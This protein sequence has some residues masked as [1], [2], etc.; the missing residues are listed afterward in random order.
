MEF[1][2]LQSRF[3]FWWENVGS[4]VE[5]RSF[6]ALYR[7]EMKAYLLSVA[8]RRGGLTKKDLESGLRFTVARK[9]EA[10]RDHIVALILGGW[11]LGARYI[12]SPSGA[13]EA[14]E[15][16]KKTYRREIERYGGKEE[17]VLVVM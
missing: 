15:W 4:A 16:L 1:L 2:Q 7:G 14:R 9:T 13:S 3:L 8:G 5:L 11:L 10:P 12:L 6:S 17:Y